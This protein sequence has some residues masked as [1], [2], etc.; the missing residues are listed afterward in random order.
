MLVRELMATDVASVAAQSPLAEAVRLLATRRV[1][2]LPVVDE[3]RLVVGILSE[4]DVLRLQITQ[5][6]RA[7]LG[8]TAPPEPWPDTVSAVMTPDPVTAH[9]GSDVSS[10]A[11]TMAD[12]GWKSL[13]VVDDH[14]RLVGM[15]SRSDVI[16]ALSTADEQIRSTVQHELDRLGSG[17]WTVAVCNG[18]GSIKGV[19]S[20]QD[21]ALATA[22]ASTSPGVRRV[23]VALPLA[24]P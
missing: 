2:A 15:V 5:D 21:A 8:F 14:D 10:V 13:P 18:V 17:G 9:T 24:R 6:P 3:G 19:E 20:Q 22:V 12:T 16:A 11:L 1:S 7:H 23:D 4:A